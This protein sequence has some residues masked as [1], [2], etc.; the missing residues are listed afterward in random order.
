MCFLIAFNITSMAPAF[1]ALTLLSSVVPE[2]MFMFIGCEYSLPL[3][4]MFLSAPH[5]FLH[6][7]ALPMCVHIA[8]S[9][10]SMAPAFP[11]LFL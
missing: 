8:F 7:P 4:A 1:P 3:V 10:T 2:K 9:I 6:M 5:P 11:A